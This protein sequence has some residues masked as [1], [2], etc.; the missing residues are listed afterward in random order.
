MRASIS[1]VQAMRPADEAE[2][3]WLLRLLLLRGCSLPTDSGR[4]IRCVRPVLPRGA[5]RV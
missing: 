5:T 1:Y 4:A 2:E 3:G